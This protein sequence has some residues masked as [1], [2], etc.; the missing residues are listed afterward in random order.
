MT[1][2]FMR[3]LTN[4]TPK[5][6]TIARTIFNCLSDVGWPAVEAPVFLG[7]RIYFEAKFG[8]NGNLAANGPKRFPHQL[9]VQKRT[10]D[11]RG[12]EKGDPK[13]DRGSKERDH[14]CGRRSHF[15]G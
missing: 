9:F 5:A 4:N 14:R 15:E 13:I 7:V 3:S 1:G 12:I 10:I 8:R 2:E 11:L 6:C